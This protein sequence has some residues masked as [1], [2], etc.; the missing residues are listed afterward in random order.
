MGD[1]HERF[2][3]RFVHLNGHSFVSLCP[4]DNMFAVEKRLLE[5]TDLAEILF[6]SRMNRYAGF[7]IAVQFSEFSPLIHKGGSQ[8]NIV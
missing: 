6:S 8:L 3:R 5:N 1:V 7:D 2:R 4:G